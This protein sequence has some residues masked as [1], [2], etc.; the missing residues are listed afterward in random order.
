[1]RSIRI[2]GLTGGTGSG[3]SAAARRFEEHGIPVVDADKVG[4]RILAPGGAAEDAVKAAFG[5]DILT[6]GRIDRAKLG[7][8]VFGNPQALE[9]LN[10]LVQPALFLGIAEDMERLAQA[11]H[12]HAIIDAALL[13]EGGRKEGILCGLILVLADREL[14]VKRLV[15]LRGMSPEEAEQRIDAQTDP[16]TKI[17]AADWLIHNTGTLEDLYN[18]VDHIVTAIHHGELPRAPR[19]MAYTHEAVCWRI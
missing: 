18:R 15:E 17:R 14:R 16:D 1:M 8:L 9:K 4:H 6:E 7:S 12:A 2:Y 11:G 10:H 13:A 19:Q 3:K 5:D